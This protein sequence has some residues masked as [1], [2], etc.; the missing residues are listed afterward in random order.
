MCFSHY[1]PVPAWNRWDLEIFETGNMLFLCVL[2]PH[3]SFISFP[4]PFLLMIVKPGSFYLLFSAWLRV[5]GPVE[6]SETNGRQR[7]APVDGGHPEGRL[8]R[9]YGCV[10]LP[11]LVH[12]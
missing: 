5:T 10:H 8:D 7:T 3:S 2:W 6:Q 1:F 12:T 11:F 9:V 4:N